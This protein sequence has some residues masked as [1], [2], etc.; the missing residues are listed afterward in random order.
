MLGLSGFA[1]DFGQIQGLLVEAL[2]VIVG[3]YAVVVSRRD[4]FERI[5]LLLQTVGRNHQ[6]WLRR[7]QFFQI[8]IV[9]R[10]KV[11]VFAI[12]EAGQA[13]GHGRG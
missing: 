10:T 1:N 8:D 12:F 2:P 9:N 4:L 5:G 11:G 13:G 7:G 6:L 3:V